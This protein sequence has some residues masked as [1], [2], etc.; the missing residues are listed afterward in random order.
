MPRTGNGGAGRPQ[1]RRPRHWRALAVWSA[2]PG[3]HHNASLAVRA[4]ANALTFALPASSP[5]GDDPHADLHRQMAL[6]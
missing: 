1:A 6:V 3:R 5:S 2:V 4:T